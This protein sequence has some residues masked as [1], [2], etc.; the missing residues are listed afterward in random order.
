MF[1]SSISV[2]GASEEAKTETTFPTPETPYGRSKWLA[3]G[4]HRAWFEE[5]GDRRLVI[6]R[7]AVIFGKAEGGNFTRLAKLLRSGLFV[8]PGRKDT[9]KACFYVEDLVDALQFALASSGRY[10]L[11][12]GS[13]PDRYTIE[14]IVKAFKRQHF[15]D[16]R[17]VVVPQWAIMILASALRPFSAMKLGI[18]PERVLKLVRSTDVIPEWLNSQGQ[19]PSDMLEHA[20]SR[21]NA[22][23]NGRFD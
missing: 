16:A 15:T 18:H 13:Y 7:P 9:I 17:E 3:E 11:F 12:N 20:L 10:V 8:Y 23:S 4:I 2:Y 14:E 19:A 6:C 1:T 5:A 21:W 22:D